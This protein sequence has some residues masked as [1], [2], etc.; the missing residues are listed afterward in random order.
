MGSLL[1]P[2]S[3]LRPSLEY[4]QA[5]VA[6]PYDVI[7][8]DEARELSIGQPWSFLH[9]SRPEIDLPSDGD[10][11]STEIYRKGSKYLQKML[12]AGVLVRDKRPSFYIY[13]IE[14]DGKSQTGFVG[15][16]S[17]EAYEKNLIRR[18]ELTRPDKE[19]DR[20][21]Q[22]LSVNAH[23]GPVLA[24]HSSNQ[25]LN[26]ISQCFCDE[27]SPE[28]SVEH[29]G[30]THSLWSIHKPELV[31]KIMT[32]FNNLGVIYIAD[33]HHRSAAA[34]RVAKIKRDANPRHN[35]RE[36]Y[37]RFLVVSFPETEVRILDYNRVVKGFNNLSQ[38]DFLAALENNF[39]VSVSSSPVRPTRSLS[40]GLYLH[41]K[42]Y[43][44]NY[45]GDIK[46]YSSE[47]D[48]LDVNILQ[49]SI[50]SPILKIG[51]PRIDPRIG[52]VGGTRGLSELERLV[53]SGSWSVA[54]SLFPTSMNQL[55]A[56]ANESK[57]MPPKSTW[58]EPKLADGLVSLALD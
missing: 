2:F 39:R 28:Y 58:F 52:F 56:V 43:E 19:K 14:S 37:N 5:V 47:T 15:A 36:P 12:D 24:V 9:I 49:N 48:I 10:F 8:R 17:V 50:L 30:A 18:H 42:W 29:Q 54:F 45:L 31:Q 46:G 55:M 22:I 16:G 7:S 53:D 1:A 35:G 6:P 34:S 40:F 11:S 57:I 41:G 3:A 44:I 25:P 13:R 26:T 4:A 20:V 23:T 51:D 32:E 33:G 21:D 38:G 27:N